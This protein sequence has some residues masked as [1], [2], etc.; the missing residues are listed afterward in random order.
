MTKLSKTILAAI[1]LAAIANVGVLASSL[2][3]QGRHGLCVWWAREDIGDGHGIERQ[4]HEMM[5]KH[6]KKV[7]DNT[8]F[9]MNQGSLYYVAGRIDPGGNFFV[10]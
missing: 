7:P 9:F 1:A 3:F 8:V 2:G 5:M 4:N 6:S 10:N